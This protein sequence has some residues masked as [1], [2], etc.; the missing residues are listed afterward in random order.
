MQTPRNRVS[1]TG[2]KRPFQLRWGAR[3]PSRPALLLH[4]PP[5]GSQIDRRVEPPTARR[6]SWWREATSS[7]VAEL[8]LAG[9]RF[10]S[11]VAAFAHRKRS[12]L[13]RWNFS[14]RET[15]PAHRTPSLLPG[16]LLCSR[17]TVFAHAAERWSPLAGCNR[18]SATP[19]W[20]FAQRLRCNLDNFQSE[21]AH[22]LNSAHGSGDKERGRAAR[23][24]SHGPTRWKVEIKM[25]DSHHAISN[26]D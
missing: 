15:P 13:T 9:D 26:K 22:A 25:E 21:T 10:R 6:G 18:G 12:L 17:E 5:T 11:Q 2:G 20:L 19:V 3:P 16:S 4:R 8:F 14:P 1:A 7:H 24:G 23:C